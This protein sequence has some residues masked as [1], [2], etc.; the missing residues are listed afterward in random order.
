MA[1]DAQTEQPAGNQG[2]VGAVLSSVS[3][4]ATYTYDT[5]ASSANYTYTQAANLVGS[6]AGSNPAT[7]DNSTTAND[8]TNDT[9]DE[10]TAP[11]ST[12]A[13]P[14]EEHQEEKERGPSNKDRVGKSQQ[15]IGTEYDI[16]TSAGL[17]STLSRDDDNTDAAKKEASQHKAHKAAVGQD[18][19]KQSSPQH[20]DES[21]P[22][23]EGSANEAA[24]PTHEDDDPDTAT[25]DG[26]G[27]KLKNKVK[28][29][30]KVI[31]GK[32]HKDHEKVE[33]G[34]SIKAGTA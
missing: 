24:Q 12:S 4:G 25:H 10:D 32:L 14:E 22:Q 20:S 23:K 17:G 19:A 31:S 2:Y 6:V 13:L 27:S 11:S 28:G 5:V 8:D 7:A 29:E 1:S 26:L 18:Y 34:K 15:E 33:L 16:P 21:T 30:A 3:S 9:K